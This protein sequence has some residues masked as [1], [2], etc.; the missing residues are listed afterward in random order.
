M[1]ANDSSFVHSLNTAGSSMV[2]VGNNYNTTHHH[3]SGIS[4]EDKAKIPPALCTTDP[5][6]DKVRIETT[7]GILLRDSYKWILDNPK[8]LSWRDDSLDSRL[9]WI[10]GDPGKGK[11]MLMC[12]II[13]ELEASRLGN[14]EHPFFLSYFF[15]QATN[16]GL[17]S[18]TAV[19]RGLIYML[20]TQQ[21]SLLSHL[22]DKREYIA[23][24]WNS[25]VVM[26]EIFRSVLADPGLQEAYFIVDALDEC[27]DELSYLLDMISSTCSR[28]RWIVSSRNRCEI[29]EHLG[30]QPLKTNISL[31]LNEES[32]SQAVDHFINYRTHRLVEKKKIKNDVAEQ[33]HDHLSKNSEGTFLWVSL[34]CQRLEKCR[35][36]EIRNELM[37]F[38]M[39]LTNLYQRMLAQISSDSSSVLYARLLATVSTV[40]R[41]LTFPELIAMEGLDLD[42]TMLPDIIAECGSFITTKENTVFFIH[43]SAKEFL[44]KESGPVLFR[45]GLAQH[46]I[47]LFQRSITILQALH[48]DLFG[49][50]RLGVTVEE[51]IRNRPE[52]DPLR[53]L[54][55]ACISWADHLQIAFKLDQ[56]GEFDDTSSL[57][58]LAVDFIK[59]KFLFWLEALSLCQKLSVAVKV[60]VFLKNLL[61]SRPPL[62]S[63]DLVEDALRFCSSF[64][65]IIERS[66]LQTYAS[67]LV[68]SPEKSLIR[69][70]FKYCTPD[71]FAK[72]PEVDKNWNVVQTRYDHPHPGD[73]EDPGD[74][75]VT[76]FLQDS[77]QLLSISGTMNITIWQVEDGSINKTAQIHDLIGARVRISS[78]LKWLVAITLPFISS[79]SLQVRDFSSNKV[80]RIKELTSPS[81]VQGIEISPNN[82]WLAVCYEEVLELYDLNLIKP[83]VGP[84]EPR[85]TVDYPET[86]KAAY[87]IA[88]SS[89]STLMA[90]GITC[91]FDI[92]TGR[93]YHRHP[94][95]KENVAWV[96]K[97][98]PGTYTLALCTNEHDIYLWRVYEGVYEQW[99]LPHE[100]DALGFSHSET[101]IAILGED[102]VYLYDLEKRTLIQSVS[103]SLRS[104]Y[105]QMALSCDGQTVVISAEGEV[106]VL[107]IRT[108]LAQSSP[109]IPPSMIEYHMS[110]DW[111]LMARHIGERFEVRDTTTG[112]IISELQS[113]PFGGTAIELATFSPNGQVLLFTYKRPYDSHIFAWNL[114][115]N[116]LYDFGSHVCDIGVAVSDDGG[117]E[118]YWF[119]TASRYCV[120][121]WGITTGE[122]KKLIN[123]QN[124]MFRDV[125]QIAF[126]GSRLGVL[127]LFEDSHSCRW[128]FSL[129]DTRTGEQLHR[130]MS[131]RPMDFLNRHSPYRAVLRLSPNGT[132]GMI[133]DPNTCRLFLW[134]SEGNTSDSRFWTHFSGHFFLDNETLCTQQGHF[135]IYSIPGQ[136]TQ[137]VLY[138]KG[139]R[140]GHTQDDPFLYSA[141]RKFEGYSY[142]CGVEEHWLYLDNMPML[143]IPA[144]YR[145]D[146]LGNMACGHDYVV[147]QASSGLYSIRFKENA[148][149][150]I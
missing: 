51:A 15:C 11:T 62:E 96:Q 80:F 84:I 5:R 60:L 69:G 130:V 135:S 54:K 66:P 56:Q 127:M 81:I 73:P 65:C 150:F 27:L 39:G 35:A 85:H 68:F 95:P 71:V 43:Q 1:Q 59:D 33:V 46:H 92:Q 114:T 78:D 61:P 140:Q 88:F 19:L 128:D 17:N 70:R 129:F 4:D 99:S 25:R 9:L 112:T 107:H 38:P 124:D 23:A 100:V 102:Y 42:E 120:S 119:A 103:I 90:L 40:F 145:P 14:T 86:L 141:I 26:E 91:A 8:F 10:R 34:A 123:P 98:V 139:V 144:Q 22:D 63:E 143:W 97:F 121:V 93:W 31:E 125:G 13:D 29:Q 132:S 74:F 146:E 28:A 109:L 106:L 30:D 21:P 48:K 149:D 111:G 45:S 52:P 44:V 122:H 117:E 116:L 77:R 24:H 18:Y 126:T 6:D 113:L 147:V 87:I 76:K 49:L 50:V 67:G 82:Q 142:G 148:R 108:I 137:S 58:N 131:W 3:H 89:D 20:V 115:D 64:N 118:G 37:Q 101:W 75:V 83:E 47:T 7:N 12:G 36:W 16:S 134:D 133:Y 104:G 94:P 72:L 2:Q 105:R 32:I 138:G 110:D 57:I 136:T 53:G 55:Y 79:Y 41:P